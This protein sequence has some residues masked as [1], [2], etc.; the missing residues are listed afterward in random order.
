MMMG[1]VKTKPENINIVKRLYE[2]THADYKATKKIDCFYNSLVSAM[3]DQA[4]IEE[5]GREARFNLWGSGQEAA[6]L[7]ASIKKY[8]WHFQE[9]YGTNQ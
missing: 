1:I 2:Q 4:Y 9:K 7:D 8:H 6:A 3:A 5:N